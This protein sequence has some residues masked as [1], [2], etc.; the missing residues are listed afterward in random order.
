V[1]LGWSASAIADVASQL[2][3][4]R[5][6]NDA[7]ATRLASAILRTAERVLAFPGSGRVGRV[8]GTREAVVPGSRLVLVY[9]L[10]SDTVHISRVL[11]GAQE[12][13]P[14]NETEARP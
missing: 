6:D 5:I 9:V 1:K 2:E 11:H 14:S 7:A 13:P 10:T 3:F 12:W 4:V 8:L